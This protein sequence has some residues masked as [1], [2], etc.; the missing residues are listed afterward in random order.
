MKSCPFC[1]EEIQ[2][3]AIVCK[4]CGRDLAPV[5]AASPPPAAPK[6][7]RWGR[8]ALYAFLGLMALGFVLQGAGVSSTGRQALTPEHYA[9]IDAVHAKHAW[10][11]P[12]AIE[13]P[14]GIVVLDYE[15][16]A[17]FLIPPKTFGQERLLGVREASC[18]SAFRTIA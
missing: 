1:A 8:R 17:G 9:A 11:Q 5:A 3:A 16:P 7:S 2:D 4:H 15:V 18:R 6:G 12:K 10:I 13:L 14:S